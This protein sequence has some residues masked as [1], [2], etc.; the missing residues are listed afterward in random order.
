MP[1]FKL[2]NALKTAQAASVKTLDSAP[3]HT[4]HPQALL[5]QFMNHPSVSGSTSGSQDAHAHTRGFIR[6]SLPQLWQVLQ[7]LGAPI[8]PTNAHA[9]AQLSFHGPSGTW[10]QITEFDSYG[11]EGPDQRLQQ[12]LGN[13]KNRLNH[14]LAETLIDPETGQSAATVLTR[15]WQ[16]A[17]HLDHMTD[18]GNYRFIILSTLKD[19]ITHGGGCE[20][21]IIARLWPCLVNM[22]HVYMD[23]TQQLLSSDHRQDQEVDEA[24][25]EAIRLSLFAPEAPQADLP[26]LAE[27]EKQDLQTA[28]SLSLLPN[29]PPSTLPDNSE[30]QQ[31][32]DYAIALALSGCTP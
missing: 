15:A 31:A 26:D 16:L 25:A 1:H 14:A 21:G 11:S 9:D 6:Q 18:Y 17:Q 2:I 8:F 27:Q 30:H 28:L 10:Q 13:K 20:A 4:D 23:M 29:T 12:L 32:N 3:G 22:A 24:T 7:D 19:N 5:Q